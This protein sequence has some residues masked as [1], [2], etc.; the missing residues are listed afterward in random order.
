M[1]SNLPSI[2]KMKPTKATHVFPSEARF[3]SPSPVNTLGSYEVRSQFGTLLPDGKGFGSESRRFNFLGVGLSEF[4]NQSPSGEKYFLTNKIGILGKSKSSDIR[5]IKNKTTHKTIGIGRESMKK[6][7]VD[8]ILAN[9][10]GFPG[11]G[12]YEHKSQ[13][14]S[15]NGHGSYS[16]RNRLYEEDKRL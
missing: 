8:Q 5:D 12:M 2:V 9:R 11:A 7:Y 14:E 13:F 3:K 1:K 15:Q 6:I 4:P 10:D 16:I